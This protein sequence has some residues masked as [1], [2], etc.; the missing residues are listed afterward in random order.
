MQHRGAIRVLD[1]NGQEVV[2][3]P[4]LIARL[5]DEELKRIVGDLPGKTPPEAIPAEVE[6]Y[7]Q[8]RVLSEDLIVRGE[9]S[10]S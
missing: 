2:H 7:T 5:F 3:T 4:E 10:P 6:L 1:E 8:A 9:F